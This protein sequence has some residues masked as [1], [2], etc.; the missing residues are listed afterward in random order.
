MPPARRRSSSLSPDQ[1]LFQRW[2]LRDDG[3]PGRESPVSDPGTT[4][5]PG[6]GKCTR[7]ARCSPS[8]PLIRATTSRN[9]P[10][11]ASWIPSPSRCS[12]PGRSPP[13]AFRE[14]A[15][16][17]LSGGSV[18]LHPFL[19]ERVHVRASAGGELFGI[20]HTN[21]SPSGF[22]T[23]T[24]HGASLRAIYNHDGLDHLAP[25][26][27]GFT[28]YT[29]RGGPLNAEGKPVRGSDSRP[30]TSPE[31]TIPSSDPAYYLSVRGL[32]ES[33]SPNQPRGAVTAFGP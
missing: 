2:D 27:D 13:A 7:T 24:V 22:Q 33:R 19:Q 11:S 9:N 3:P 30:P 6:H 14:S 10:G 5:G 25:G 29:G 4:Q 26:P 23:L 1:G 20:W 15:E 28:V 12:R 17:L 21:G 18:L 8:G 32:G 31:M 16:S